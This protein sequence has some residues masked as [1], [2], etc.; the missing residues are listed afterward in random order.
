MIEPEALLA[1]IPGDMPQGIDLRN[2]SHKPELYDARVALRA[3]R[4]REE[5][6][7]PGVRPDWRSVE[8][9]CGVI[10]TDQSKDLE[11][12]AGLAEALIRNDGFAGFAAAGLRR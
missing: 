7:D 1:P 11:A 3:A 8:A 4:Q 2:P 9:L 12:A 10:L 6:G 5:A